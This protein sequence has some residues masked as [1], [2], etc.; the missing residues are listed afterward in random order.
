[1]RRSRPESVSFR[2]V[3]RALRKLK[4]AGL[5]RSSL[6]NQSG[7]GRGL[8]TEAQYHAVQEELLRQ[9]GAGSIYRDLFLPDPPAR[10][11]PGA[12]LSR[13]GCW[14]P[15]AAYDIDLASS[16]FIRRQEYRHRVRPARRH[17]H[18]SSVLTGYTGGADSHPDFTA[19]DMTQ[20]VHKSCSARISQT[21]ETRIENVPTRR[22][23]AERFLPRCPSESRSMAASN[24]TDAEE[25]RQAIPTPHARRI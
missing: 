17:A 25:E 15:A 21:P 12:S 19:D 8:I 24:Y 18:S 23:A 5:A 4:E 3:P 1:L 13:H 14:K 20:A 7:I 2:E 16:Y 9:I 10:P 22:R 11:P 6:P